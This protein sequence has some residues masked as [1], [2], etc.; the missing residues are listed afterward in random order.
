MVRFYDHYYI[1]IKVYRCVF[2]CFQ[3]NR[4]NK[5]IFIYEFLFIIIDE[6][7]CGHKATGVISVVIDFE[8]QKPTRGSNNCKYVI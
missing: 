5:N 4:L 2:K 6:F 1:I 7:K 8:A 3:F